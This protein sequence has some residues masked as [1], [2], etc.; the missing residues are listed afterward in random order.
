MADVFLAHDEVLDRDVALKLLKDEYA[1]DEEFIERFKREAQS[2]A[3]LSHPNIVSIFD[4]G[5]TEDGTYYIA[6]EYLP[7][8]TLKDHILKH[9]SL[10]PPMAAE[11]ALQTA[12]ALQT[13]HKRGIIHRDVKP[14]NI[15]VAASGDVK[16]TDFGIARAADATTTSHLGDILG[17]AKY[18]SPE[19]AMGE[20]VGPASDLFSLGVVLY[21]MLTAKVPFDASTPADV[22]VRHAAGPPPHPRKLNPEVPVGMDALVMRLLARDPE[23]RYESAAELIED[24]RRVRDGLHP[25]DPPADEATTAALAAPSLRTP[26]PGGT[27]PST[28]RRSSLTLVAIIALLAL[29]TAAGAAVGWNMLQ[30]R[31]AERTPGRAAEGTPQ[32][33]K[34]AR[35]PD[36]EG[37]TDEEARERLAEAG[38]ETEVRLREGPKE[39]A[40]RVLQQSVPSGREAQE[41]SKILL[42]VGEAPRG[43][44]RVPKVVGLSYPEAEERLEESGF[45]LGG[46]KEAAS[47]T[48]PEGVISEQN[49]QPGTA[50]DAGSYVYLT[51]SIG[52]PEGSGSQGSLATENDPSE[53]VAAA[54]RGHYEAIGRGDFEEAYSYFGPTFRSQH[55]QASWISGE[56]SY[57]IESSTIHSLTV[58]EVLGRTATASVEV[59]F[60]DKTGTPRFVIVW[61]LVKEGGR[62]KLD[63]QFSAQRIG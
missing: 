34:D 10:P 28:R 58:E 20:P 13:A 56:R 57:A 8:G 59:S 39:D 40:G 43:L 36:V 62:W 12:E 16:V 50:L 22:S 11:V 31:S 55:D 18:M 29:L 23:D 60:V 17:T 7:G 47:E 33:P 42:T 30:D 53:A 3:A 38:F 15:L 14:R 24:L 51:T 1:E 21:E 6:M 9:G 48:V 45:L 27:G 26:T 32:G 41:G 61:G 19:Q 37:L 49:P 25:L 5:E 63:R 2:A 4:R 44:A 52:P 35:V 46:V 54:V